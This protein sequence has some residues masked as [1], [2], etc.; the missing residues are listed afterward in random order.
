MVEIGEEMPK[1]KLVDTEFNE[2]SI[3]G[4]ASGKPVVVAF[5]P[6]AFTSVCTKEMCT[7]R[8]SM[9]QFNSVNAKL[10]AVSV[11]GPFANKVFRDTNKLNFPILSDYNR[12][13]VEKFDVALNDFA[14]LKGYTAAKRAVFVADA[15]GVVKYRWVSN[16][17]TVE[18]DYAEINKALQEIQ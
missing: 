1:V 10:Y 16:D 14:K 9:A 2:V 8:D 15:K 7:F 17:P 5:F 18:P 13:A 11:D 6:G 12:E 3:P 4:D